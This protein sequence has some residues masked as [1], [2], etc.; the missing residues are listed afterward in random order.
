MFGLYADHLGGVSVAE[1]AAL[2]SRSEQW[3]SERIEAARLC[4]EKQVRI[5]VSTTKT[6]KGKCRQRCDREGAQP[7]H[8]IPLG[9]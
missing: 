6:C 2:S 8:F 9:A 3:I 7:Q 4:I 1:L 5:E